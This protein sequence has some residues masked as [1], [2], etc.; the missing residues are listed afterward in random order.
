MGVR[1]LEWLL[2]GGFNVELLVRSG[3][4]VGACAVALLAAS[5]RSMGV[6][7][8]FGLLALAGLGTAGVYGFDRWATRGGSPAGWILP[9]LVAGVLGLRQPPQA[10]LILVAVCALA[11]V[12]VRLRDLPW[13]KP[14]YIALAWIGVVVGLPWVLRGS[15]P[16]PVALGPVALAIAANVLACDAVDREAEAAQ[17]APKKVWWIARAVAAAGVAVAFAMGAAPLATIPGCLLL[18]LVRWPA[19]RRFAERVLD[20]ALLV[21]AL[22]AIVLMGG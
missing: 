14:V 17:I 11:L 22:A 9:C 2:S 20:G 7:P 19:D 1:R 6:G 12:H 16:A 5:A 18:A 4:W 8:D 3:I 13:A 21:G 15:A 10:I